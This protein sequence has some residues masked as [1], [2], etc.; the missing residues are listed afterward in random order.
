MS[1]KNNKIRLRLAPSP[2]GFLHIGNL[3]TALFGYL[4]VKNW[5]GKYLLR[6]E[7]TD[8]KREVA[9]ATEKLIN[10]LKTMGLEFDEGPHVGGQYGPYIQSERREIYNKFASQLLN[11]EKIY[12]CFCS[13]ERLTAM[14]TA[15]EA[16]HEAPRYDG[17]CRKLSLEE[18][19][20]RAQAGDSFVLRQK[21]PTAGEIIVRD[22]LRG[23]I[24]F[25]LADLDD[26]VLIKSNGI[27]TYQFANVIDDHL[28]EISYVTRG[29]EW[30]P[31]YPKN[32]LLYQAFDWVPPKFIH[33]PL[34]LNKTGGGKL[35]KRQGDVFVED[36]LAKGYLPEAL[37]NFCV[38][39]G[40][41][42]KNDQEIWSLEELKSKFALDGL[43]ASPAVF[44]LEKLDYFNG[45]YIRQKS[46]AELANLSRPWLQ[47]AGQDIQNEQQLQNFVGLAQDR[48]KKLSDIVELT[49]FLFELPSYDPEILRWK[50][51]TLKESLI[52]L[53]EVKGEVEKIKE[54]DWTKEN[55]EK[56]ILTWLKKNNY[57]NG[58]Y[59]WP[60]RVA[61]TGL[62][63]SPGP[64]E[65][66]WALGKA[67]TLNRLNGI[68]FTKN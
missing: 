42:P 36:Y 3:R 65:V 39:L 60:L 24:K 64:F 21:M 55:L 12:R 2:T 23:D 6:I 19:N 34:I 54:K 26:Q 22:E 38:L 9:G 35:S 15:Q 49:N 8:Q 7:D 56:S 51:L 33:F 16:N 20:R 62:K 58:D 50:T 44:D 5:K 53:Q 29:D 61:L 10:I 59:L 28:M 67:E 27:P 37:I 68:N 63:N 30:L 46:P 66:A 47:A 45:Y 18:S 52:K 40:W 41:H 32:I 11:E 48:L 25:Q 14:R 13:A 17:L 4:L 1:S 31:S 57:K 43:G